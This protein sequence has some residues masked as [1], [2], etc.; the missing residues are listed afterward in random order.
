[1]ITLCIGQ[2]E[3]GVLGSHIQKFPLL[4]LNSSQ[5]GAHIELSDIHEDVG[6]TLVHF[7]YSGTYE[8]INSPLDQFKLSL[9][10]I[11]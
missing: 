3:Y 7:L 10:I 2:E 9:T 8:T 11:I 1:M 6:H 5:Y 4:G